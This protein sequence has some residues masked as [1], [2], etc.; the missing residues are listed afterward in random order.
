MPFSFPASP[1][2]GATSTQ[3]GR[4]YVYAGN[5]TWELVAASGGGS[6]SGS[7]TIP[8]SDP[9][10]GDVSLLLHMD[11]TGSTFVDS[12]GMPKT[13]TASGDATQSATHSRFGGKSLYLDGTAD[14]L[15]ASSNG[16]VF[17][18]GDFCIEFWIRPTSSAI[19]AS[20]AR[21]P[22]QISSAAGG[23][24]TSYSS[25]VVVVFGDSGV[26]GQSGVNGGISCAIGGTFF[27]SG[28]S[29]VVN[30]D[31]WN[32]IA[33]SR[34]SGTG[35]LYVNGSLISSATASANLTGQHLCLGGYYDT[36]FLISGYMDE[37]RIT[38]GVARYTGS[39]ITLPAAA[40][41]DASSLT[42]SVTIFG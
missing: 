35:R 12:S 15:S 37:V 24:S 31:Q 33:V 9:Y 27:G 19:A 17:G 40:F 2:V 21:G 30:A 10:L 11:G 26:V 32:H 38:K 7:V 23:L 8:A 20:G 18:T 36:S 6:L 3:N 1:S 28:S 4:Q 34:E 39:T 22:L 14:R 42:L 41:P 5:N 25:G 13:I 16:F 29:A